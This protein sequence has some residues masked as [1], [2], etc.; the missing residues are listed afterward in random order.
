VPY[1]EVRVLMGKFIFILICIALCGTFSINAQ[2][3]KAT[4]N[5]VPHGWLD[6][7][8]HSEIRVPELKGRITI[9][10]SPSAEVI[11][12]VFRYSK[13]L[14]KEFSSAA[15]VNQK[16]IRACKTGSNG[17]F[18]FHGLR[19]GKYFIRVGF[20]KRSEF[21]P[22]HVIVVIDKKAKFTNENK[23]DIHLQIAH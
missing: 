8:E 21:N 2:C 13:K 14:H 3:R 12:E 18:A 6:Y 16:R 22:T 5:E 15:T 4:S 20:I 19:R 1:T 10:E 9:S 17:K 7:I 23:L 11:V